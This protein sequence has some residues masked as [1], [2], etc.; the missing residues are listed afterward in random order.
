MTTVIIDFMSFRLLIMVLKHILFSN[1]SMY[2]IPLLQVILMSKFTETNNEGDSLVWF[3]LVSLFNGISTFMGYLMPSV[4]L[5]KNSCGT[6]WPIVYWGLGSSYKG[7][8][9]C[10][11]MW[12][13]VY[14]GLGSLYKGI[15]PKV[16]VTAR[17]EFRL[18]YY[19]VAVQQLATTSWGL[20]HPCL[21]MCL[22]VS[23]CLC[24]CVY[25]C[26]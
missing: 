19:N 17:L 23:V 10:G 21:C 9:L 13:I 11:T 3:G 2:F 14:W 20:P 5:Q 18:A 8:S 1:F 24:L 12:P 15:S 25:V 26:V 22:C 4:I 6:M 16:N 7:I